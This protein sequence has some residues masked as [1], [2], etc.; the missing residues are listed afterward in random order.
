MLMTG[1][2][3]T[4]AA[5]VTNVTQEVKAD[6][7]KDNAASATAEGAAFTDKVLTDYTVTS[8]SG[9]SESIL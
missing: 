3:T 2:T 6:L 1:T 5:P 4:A 9:N 7:G 8:Y